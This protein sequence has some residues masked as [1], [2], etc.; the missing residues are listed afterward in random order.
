[1]GPGAV[2]D[3]PPDRL[4]SGLGRYR[5]TFIFAILPALSVADGIFSA[6][7][8]RLNYARR[9][10]LRNIKPCHEG[11]GRPVRAR[12][13]DLHRVNCVVRKLN[14]FACLAFPVLTIAK[15]PLNDRVLV[16]NW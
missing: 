3:R 15:M 13:A 2:F 12:T 14:L 5:R 16:T 10:A 6:A 11:D 7:N 4:R 8:I 1:M 9:L